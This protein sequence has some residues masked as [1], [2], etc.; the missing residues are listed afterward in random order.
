MPFPEDGGRMLGVEAHVVGKRPETINL[1]FTRL[2]LKKDFN[3]PF[4]FLISHISN[5]G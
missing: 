2:A 3:N 1:P 5:T 4:H